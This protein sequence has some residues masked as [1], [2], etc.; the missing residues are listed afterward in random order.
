MSSWKPSVRAE[1]SRRGRY[2]IEYKY[3]CPTCGHANLWWVPSRGGGKCWTCA[4]LYGSGNHTI[5]SMKAL[6]GE[7]AEHDGLQELVDSLGKRQKVAKE[8]VKEAAHEHHWKFL[9]FAKLRR[10]RIED[11]EKAGVWY[12]SVRNRI[13][14]PLSRIIQNSSE[15]RPVPIMSR[16]VSDVRKDWR[17][18]PEGTEKELYWFNPVPLTAEEI[19]LVEGPFDI[20][21]PGLLGSAVGLCGVKLYENAHLWASDMVRKGHSFAIWLD[22]DEAGKNATTPIYRVLKSIT[23]RVRIITHDKEPGDC[24]R[25]EARKVLGL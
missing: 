8:I 1:G 6:F 18:E 19:V 16:T 2:G 5:S 3:K 23:D 17:V 12:D 15:S 11:L 7:G 9:W 21:A 24:S 4:A 22:S 10:T 20:L 13:C 25:E 14:F